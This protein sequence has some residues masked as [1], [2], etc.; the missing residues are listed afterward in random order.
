MVKGGKGMEER[1]WRKGKLGE[2][3]KETE[4]SNYSNNLPKRT[5]TP[6]LDW[7]NHNMPERESDN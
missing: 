6:K 1:E 7:R 2:G 4:T 5:P 3:K